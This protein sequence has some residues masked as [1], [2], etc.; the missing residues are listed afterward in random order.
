MLEFL[1]ASEGIHSLR[2]TSNWLH[3]FRRISNRFLFGSEIHVAVMLYD[4]F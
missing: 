3:P 4:I 2:Q 1:L